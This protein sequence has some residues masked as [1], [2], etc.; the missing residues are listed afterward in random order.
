MRL[1]KAGFICILTVTLGGCAEW[2]SIR[3]YPPGAKAYI[4]GQYVGSSPC[5]IQF[6]R[7]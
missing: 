2:A 3:S 6:P 4:D 5:G 1:L 7:S